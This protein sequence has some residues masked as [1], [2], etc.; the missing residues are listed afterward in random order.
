MK[1][2][3][4]VLFAI[5]LFVQVSEAQNQQ[6]TVPDSFKVTIKVDPT[7]AKVYIDGQPYTAENPPF[8]SVGKHTLKA[9]KDGYKPFE[10][11]IL[12]SA[13]G[14]VFSVILSKV[15]P[16]VVNIYSEPSNALIKVDGEVKGNTDKG[17]F[18]MPGEHTLELELTDYVTVSEKIVVSP[19]Q[20]KNNFRYK[21]VRNKGIIDLTVVPE[22]AVVKFNGIELIKPYHFEITPGNYSLDIS[23]EYHSSYSTVL[24]L[25][26][27]ETI[28][29]TINLEKNSGNLS[30][31]LT[32]AGA[33]LKINDKIY[34]YADEIQLYPGRYELMMSAPGYYTQST[35]IDIEQG[36]T[37]KLSF[38][39]QPIVGNLQ[40]SVS[41]A[42]AKFTL[43]S[44]NNEV[45]SWSGASIIPS[46]KIG[47]YELT[48]SAKGY[49]T[50]HYKI[51]IS[52]GVTTMLDIQL[53]PGS[54]GPAMAFVPGG[55][56]TM[57]CTSNRSDCNEDEFPNRNIAVKS[58]Y[59]SK[60]E[61]TVKQFS[62]FVQATGYK[63]VAETE[64]SSL[65]WSEEGW[66]PVKGV[67]WRFNEKGE[68]LKTE[69]YSKPVIYISW[70]DAIEFCNWLSEKDGLTPAYTIVKTQ[71]DPSNKSDLDK[72]RW[73]VT[74]NI[75]ANGYRLP[76]EIEWEYAA[77]GGATTGNLEYAGSNSI[78]EVGWYNGNSVHKLNPVAGK[79]P[80]AL[81]IYD[82][83][84]NVWEWC[85][86]W[87][88]NY[89]S[90]GYDPAGPPSGK[91]KVIRGGS[92][93]TE[94]PG[95]K[96]SYRGSETAS[97]RY[98]IV[99]FRVV[100][101]G[102]E[103]FFNT[104]LSDPENPSDGSGSPS[105]NKQGG[106]ENLDPITLTN[107]M[108]VEMEEIVKDAQN[109]AASQSDNSFTGYT[110]PEALTK[111]KAGLYVP[112]VFAEL[113][114]LNGVSH[115]LKSD[116]TP[117]TEIMMIFT[118]DEIK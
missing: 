84:G 49:K 17:I 25:G 42:D 8:L 71:K 37:E 33:T 78:S 16:A 28:K 113:I 85:W 11:D 43:T 50:S 66:K 112:I 79:K 116:G 52:D 104:E 31:K 6:A 44:F 91:F 114:I 41:P 61:V 45:E 57:G 107:R 34:G 90:S 29:Q 5:L 67:N 109:Y 51:K 47:D 10:Q 48:V 73:K 97:S 59:M 105:A 35:T 38:S 54:S 74:G 72:V 117:V 89:K 12:G 32:P 65:V 21:L 69:D 106:Y 23:A 27:G 19:D 26:V 24:K 46:I 111:D 58:F 3:I 4:V 63:T 18:L 75:S 39:L 22:N 115:A 83:S 64:G 9:V 56:F 80:N 62:E 55:T 70:Y 13:T 92:W 82:L 20:S 94:S 118:K 7:D 86:D 103:A 76:T 99:G 2:N 100:S 81:D 15:T 95:C 30:I 93:D 98:P 110:V 1:K 60:T 14:T 87:Y 40:V 53:Q 77:K 68:E 88:D 36:R 108:A 102:K 101:S 96:V